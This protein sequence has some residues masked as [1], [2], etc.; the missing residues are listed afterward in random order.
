M[1][2]QEFPLAWRW[3]DARYA[4]FPPDVLAQLCPCSLEE[5]SRLFELAVALSRSEDPAAQRFNAEGAPEQV[6]AWLQARQPRLQEEVFV[7]WSADTALRL[8]WTTFVQRWD[9][10]CYPSSDDVTVFPQHGN[11]ML[12]YHHWEEFEFRQDTLA[13]QL[14]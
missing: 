11:W 7:C 14:P 12:L 4:V 10:F 1:T 2:I 13:N 8:P 6:S 3:T 9:D 5:A